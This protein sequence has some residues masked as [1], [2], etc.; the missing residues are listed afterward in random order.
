MEKPLRLAVALFLA[1]LAVTSCGPIPQSISIEGA[2]SRAA[3][4]GNNGAAFF[5]IINPAP[6]ADRLMSVASDVAQS[7]E[8]H[9]TIDDGG[10]MKMIPQPQGFEV[11]ARGRLELKTGGKH[12][13]LM[14]LKES[15]EVGDTFQLTLNFEK[16]GPITII[17]PVKGM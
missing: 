6:E 17:V 5:T 15:L 1:L 10:V 3:L 12:I 8:I 9:E 2:M 11:P 7:A 4:E 13:M 14:G 16:A